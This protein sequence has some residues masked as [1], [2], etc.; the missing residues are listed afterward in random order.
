MKFILIVLMLITI[1]GCA[2]NGPTYESMQNE[3][4]KT[5]ED[6]AML[7]F[8]RTKGSGL[9]RGRS[10][11]IDL[12][13]KETGSCSYG[14]FFYRDISQGEHSIKTEIW[15]MPGECEVILHAQAGETYYFKVDPRDESFTAFM[16]GGVVGNAIE[17]SGKQCSGAFKLY[18]AS[19]EIAKE[20]MAGLK[21]SE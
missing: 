14:G 9:F 16:L 2:A 3:I 17:G 10:A 8:F 5:G 18:P 12:D 21:Q 6:Q 1:T 11:P 4:S 20:K 15:D 19:E 13:N 7:V